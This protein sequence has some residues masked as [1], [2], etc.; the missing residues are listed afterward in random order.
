M[1]SAGDLRKFRKAIPVQIVPA[2]RRIK[3]PAP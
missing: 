1:K 2:A 3:A